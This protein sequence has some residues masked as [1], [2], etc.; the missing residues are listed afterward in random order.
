MLIYGRN[1]HVDLYAWKL[2]NIVRYNDEDRI[3]V[4][5]KLGLWEYNDERVN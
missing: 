2:D 4:N 1:S 5:G 3:K